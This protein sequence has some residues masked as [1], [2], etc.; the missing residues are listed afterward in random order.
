MINSK[1]GLKYSQIRLEKVKNRWKNGD[2]L[3]FF[4]EMAVFGLEINE[5][6]SF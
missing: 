3:R 4:D 6:Y 5:I 1:I 2:S